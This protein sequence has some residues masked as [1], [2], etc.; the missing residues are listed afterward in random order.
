MYATLQRWTPVWINNGRN[1]PNQDANLI[2]M[3]RSPGNNEGSQSTASNVLTVATGTVMSNAWCDDSMDAYKGET[4]NYVGYIVNNMIC[5]FTSNMDVCYDKLSGPLMS[6]GGWP[7]RMC[8]WA[9]S[10]G[11]WNAPLIKRARMDM[12][13]HV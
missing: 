9:W 4:V 5:A 10:A 12:L 8:R 6:V 3:C 1:L 2:A 7:R 11:V 13:G